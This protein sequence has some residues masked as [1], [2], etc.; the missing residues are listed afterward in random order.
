MINNTKALFRTIFYFFLSLIFT[1]AIINAQ[2]LNTNKFQYLSPVPGSKMNSTGT[3]III[4][5]GDEFDNY[6]LDNSLVITGSKSGYHTGKIVLA[7]NNRTLLFQPDNKFADG[8]VV[9]VELNKNLRTVSNERV[10]TLRFSFETSKIDLN[11]IIR[12]DPEKYHK[13]LLS[14]FG[15]EEN[16]HQLKIDTPES[17]PIKKRYTIQSDSLPTDFPAI[18]VNLINNPTPGR[19]FL[20]PYSS[21]NPLIPNYLIITDNYGVPIYYKKMLT[22][23]TLNFLKQ[24]SGVLTYYNTG[25]YYVMDNSYNIIDSLYMGNGYTADVHECVLLDNGHS[26]LLGYDYQHVNMDTVVINGDANATVIGAVIQELDENKNVI[27]Q[28]LS[29]DH[30]K[31][32]DATDDIDLTASTVDYVHGNALEMDNDGNILLSSR[33]LDEITKINVQTGEI[34]WRMGGAY[35]ENNQFTFLNDSIGFSHQHDIRRLS[36]GDITLFDNGNL[37]SPS[38]SRVVEYKIDEAN[39]TATL[40]WEYKNNPLT[41][42]L[43]MGNN[44]RLYNQNIFIG[45]GWTFESPY[46]SEVTPDG[47]VTQSISLAS[48]EVNYRAVKYDW[49]TNLFVTNPDSVSFGY[50]AT[51]DSLVKPLEIINNSD[52][53]IEINRI[54]NRDSS[55]YVITPL[56]VIIPASGKATIQVVYKPQDNEKHTDDLYLQWN[57]KDERIARIVPLKATDVTNVAN[58]FQILRKYT[59]KQNYPNPFNPITKINFTIA[60]AG[61]VSLKVYDILGQKIKTLINR[62][63]AKGSYSINFNGKNLPSGV[64]VYTLSV[65]E[66]KN[67]KKMIL[68]K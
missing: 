19:I 7:E 12:S 27:F 64:Y 30:F 17:V 11:R 50:A 21:T 46:I 63:M 8:D 62:R 45:W 43:A 58:N 38:F 16:F 51:G 39:M 26:L 24:S 15:N 59:L 2:D 35:C 4:R 20:A 5:F 68:L 9:T 22:E 52:S 23:R 60:K 56:P 53:E 65:N 1:S 48:N 61:K 40:V 10:P 67:S 32:T 37:H 14:E 42:S 3:N 28:W 29:W 47:I 13:L 33:N 49:K 31:I 44:Q 25:K 6:N 54:L 34:M 41:F 66:Y 55:F 18:S 36:N 57:R